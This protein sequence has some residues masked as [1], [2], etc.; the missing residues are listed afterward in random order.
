MLSKTLS[1]RVAAALGAEVTGVTPLTGGCVATVVRAD[2]ADGQ[3]VVIK[4]LPPADPVGLMPEAHALRALAPHAPAPEVLH[5]VHD[6]LVMTFLD[7]ADAPSEGPG[8]ELHAAEL[9]AELH[10]A[11]APRFGLDAPTAIGGLLQPNDWRHSWI[12]F[13]RDLRIRHMSEQAQRVGNLPPDV[14]RSVEHLA[15]RLDEFQ[16]FNFV[17]LLY[18][19]PR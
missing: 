4:T 12:D 19:V 14:A 1:Q 3:A 10:N 8:V 17:F 5:S 6:L 18:S 13:Y 16:C 9:L 2:L 15:G 7:A 11:T